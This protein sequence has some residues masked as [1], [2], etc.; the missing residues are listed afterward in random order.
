MKNPAASIKARLQNH[1]RAKRI[2]LG[3]L[4]ER[5]A[6][7]RLIARL[8][9]SNYAQRFVL[10]GAQLFA[11]W[12]GNPHRPTRDAD[13]LSFGDVSKEA[14]EAIFTEVCAVSMPEEDGLEWWDISADA[15]REDNIYGGMRVRLTATLGQARIPVQ[16]DIGYGDSV[17]PEPVMI[18]W[19]SVLDFPSVSL[20]AYPPETVIAEKLEA[21]VSLGLA[22]SRMK[23]FYDLHWMSRHMA[24]EGAALSASIEATFSRR[25]TTIPAG[26]PEAFTDVFSD[27]SDKQAQWKGFLRKSRLENLELSDVIAGIR[28]FLLPLL[29]EGHTRIAEQSWQPGRGWIDTT[30]QS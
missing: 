13:F 3:P 20:L 14:L 27:R 18:E 2:E 5:F 22:N 10:K 16:I 9:R 29:E 24:F 11:V 8:S 30:R 21:A 1:A 28:A 7:D 17:T 19:H 15:I 6:L 12:T 23:D 26:V 4:L 25:K